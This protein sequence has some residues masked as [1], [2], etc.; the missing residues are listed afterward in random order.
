MISDWVLYVIV[1]FLAAKMFKKAT[2]WHLSDKDPAY[3]WW[4]DE[5]DCG[6][7][8]NLLTM[9]KKVILIQYYYKL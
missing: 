6:A 9:S 7:I 3:F 5:R 2:I 8:N 1:S 4:R